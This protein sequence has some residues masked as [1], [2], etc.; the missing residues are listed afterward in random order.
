[1]KEAT[2]IFLTIIGL[3]LILAGG[4][5]FMVTT[6]PGVALIVAVWGLKL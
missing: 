2:K 6:I 4:V 1:M 5:D 3:I